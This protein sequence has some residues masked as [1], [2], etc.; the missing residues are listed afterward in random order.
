[1]KL[2]LQQLKV[3][4]TIARQQPGAGGRRPLCLSKGAVSQALQEL[5]AP[6]RRAAVRPGAPQ[7]PAQQRGA[8]AATAAADEMLTRMQ[9]IEQLFQPG[10]QSPAAS[11][12]SVPAR[13]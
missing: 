1:M 12:A 8:P 2:A 5:G 4:A 9:E 3:F 7:P 13:P 10:C 11:C 6:A